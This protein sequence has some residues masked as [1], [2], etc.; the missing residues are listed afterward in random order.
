[1]R[2][3]KMAHSLINFSHCI[4]SVGGLNLDCSCLTECEK[5]LIDKNE[6][7]LL[8]KLNQGRACSG[9]LITESYVYCIGGRCDGD[10]GLL[11]VEKINVRLEKLW[12]IVNIK[13]SLGILSPRNSFKCIPITD[14][15]Y[16]MIGGYDKKDVML[17]ESIHLF[18]NDKDISVMNKDKLGMVDSFYWSSTYTMTA[19]H[20]HIVSSNRNIHSY[21]IEKKTWEVIKKISWIS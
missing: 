1:M 2:I 20:I 15:Q 17:D 3:P 12:E 8:P 16:L 7:Y 13:D 4:Y 6:F 10:M 21:S 5:Y 19:H 9:L 14:G 11:K 18:A